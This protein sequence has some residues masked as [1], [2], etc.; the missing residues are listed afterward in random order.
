MDKMSGKVED[1][2]CNTKAQ[3]LKVMRKIASDIEI[4]DAKGFI[5]KDI[6]IDNIMLDKKNVPHFID[7]GACKIRKNSEAHDYIEKLRKENIYPDHVL[8]GLI[9]EDHAKRPARVK[10]LGHYIN[11]LKRAEEGQPF[12]SIKEYYNTPH[13][14]EIEIQAAKRKFMENRHKRMQARKVKT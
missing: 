2:K 4:M 5:M 3:Q 10:Q 7:F 1:L 6:H 13:E 11:Y 12:L 8:D 9:E 14:C